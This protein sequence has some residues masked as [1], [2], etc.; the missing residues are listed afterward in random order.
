[1]RDR[2]AVLIA[3]VT[4][5]EEA[6]QPD[7]ERDD[8]DHQDVQGETGPRDDQDDQQCEQEQHSRILVT[9]ELFGKYTR[10]GASY[11]MAWAVPEDQG[12][13]TAGYCAFFFTSCRLIK[14][15]QCMKVVWAIP[16]CS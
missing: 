16:A 6:D 8:G 11:P 12:K 13:N 4:G 7:N 3:V 14:Y 10:V 9:A 1:M 5:D 15:G 2:P